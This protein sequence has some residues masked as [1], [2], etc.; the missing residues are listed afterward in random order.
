MI[1]CLLGLRHLTWLGEWP[2]P[3]SIELLRVELYYYEAYGPLSGSRVRYARD[4]VE[5]ENGFPTDLHKGA[6][7]AT[8]PKY[9]P[10]LSPASGG[11]DF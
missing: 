2:G 10:P 3:D 1:K 8:D 7:V 4:G 6:F 9:T 11:G 5:Q